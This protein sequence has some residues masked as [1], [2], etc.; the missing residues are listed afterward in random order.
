ME[1]T[2]NGILLIDKPKNITSYKVVDRIKKHFHLYKVGH[3]GTLDPFAT[4]LLIILIGS[5]T[6]ISSQF[7]NCNKSYEGLMKLGKETDTYDLTGKVVNVIDASKVTAQKLSKVIKSFT[8][9]IK[10]KP[11]LFSAIKI[12]GQKAYNI[13]RKEKSIELASR[14]VE[15]FELS[16]DALT[17]G[18]HPN[19]AFR[20]RVSKGTYIRSLAHDIG[21]ALEVGAHLEE[22][23]RTE[24][25]HFSIYDA[26]SLDGVLKWDT[27]E[28]QHH[29]IEEKIVSVQ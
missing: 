5:A 11:P 8:G 20:C 16:A 4:G 25:G 23:R 14:E 19:A 6:K 24:V 10:Q 22:L 3:G 28:L 13:A 2:I 26:N 17:E 12:N 1:Q 15:V 7:L 27:K 21:K 29:I 9:P 18:K